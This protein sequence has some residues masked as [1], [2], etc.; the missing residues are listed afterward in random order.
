M[1]HFYIRNGELDD[2]KTILEKLYRVNPEDV[3]TVKG[4][5]LVARNKNDQA[6]ALKYSAELLKIDKSPDNQIIQIET[7]LEAGLADEARVK[8]ESFREKYPDDPRAMFLQAWQTARQGKL[9]EA[10]KIS[11]KNLEVDKN[12]PRAWLLRGQINLALNNYNQAV[13]DLQKSKTLRD[14]PDVRIDLARVYMRTGRVEQAI[15][16]LK[17][18]T[19]EQGSPVARNML[20]QAYYADGKTDRLAKFY[21][22]TIEKFPND[23]YWHNH[24]GEFNLTNKN[25][26]K[27]Y[28]LFD[29]AYQNSLKINSELPNTQAFDGKMRALLQSKKYDQLLTESTKFL[30]GPLASV[31]YARM[32][33]AKAAVGE[34]DAAIQYFRRALEKAG[35]N[36]DMIIEILREMNSIVGFDETIKWCQEKLQTQPNSIAVNFALFNIYNNN[37][38]YN[39]ATEYIDNCIKISAD[40]DKDATVYRANKASALYSAFRKTN[41][42]AYLEKAIEEY[43]SILRKQPNNITVLNNLAYTLVDNNVDIQKALDYAEKAYKAVPNNPSVLDTYGY[44][45]LKNGKAKEAVEFIQR[46]LQ[47]YEEGKIN[48]PAE[49]YEHIAMAKEELGQDSDAVE[50][51]KSALKFIG[52]DG[53][54]EIKARISAA[55]ERLSKK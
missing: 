5:L 24:A 11:N 44:V 38:Q 12:N 40:N 17:V 45:L 2:A 50:A 41:D 13:D 6:G 51:Y 39:K 28:Q 36:E 42:K 47:L 9:E 21:Q 7:Y 19:N 26:D 54:K 8:L 25:F 27:A 33:D 10:L 30:D 29:T 37:Q 1:W 20:E 32:A 18:A 55:I 52:E 43:E 15:T 49:V 34:K 4:L 14:D 46:S 3:N 53:S 31:A 16:E 35:T 48:A 23:V 22:E